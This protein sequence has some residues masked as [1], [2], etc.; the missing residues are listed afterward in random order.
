MKTCPTCG[1]EFKSKLSKQ[2]YCSRTCWD[3]RNPHI[4][5]T[6]GITFYGGAKNAKYCSHKCHSNAGRKTL[7]CLNCGQMFTVRKYV[8]RSYCSREC[9]TQQ[10]AP[11]R[12]K[13]TLYTCAVCG[14]EFKAKTCHNRR[15]CSQACAGEGLHISK[16]QNW[17]SINCEWCGKEFTRYS[18]IKVRFCSRD[19]FSAWHS[20]NKSGENAPGYIH[21]K[22][23][24]DRGSNWERQRGLALKRDGYKCQICH[25]K[26]GLKPYD[27]G[28]HH[29]KP[30]HTF[31]GDY[32]SANELSN[33]ITLC[34]F[35]HRAVE[36]G[37]VAC[38][39]P[40]L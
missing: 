1:K 16:D 25:R 13:Q 19:C 17:Q 32:K 7:T 40:L 12:A 30:Y 10:I 35:C 4:C 24:P 34:V 22:Y 39:M 15:Y 33:L 8:N 18:V 37:K 2:R 36:R 11:K 38:P 5:H 6:C 31:D 29:I 14:K 9:A 27:H 3:K 28:I 20:E 21:G 26:I 23:T